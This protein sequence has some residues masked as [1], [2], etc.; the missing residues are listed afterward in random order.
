KIGV[1]GAHF[2]ETLGCRN[3]A[4][5][6]EPDSYGSTGDAAEKWQSAYTRTFSACMDR[7]EP[8]P[9]TAAGDLPQSSKVTLGSRQ[10]KAKSSNAPPKSK[11][12]RG[13]K[14]KKKGAAVQAPNSEPQEVQPPVIAPAA[15]ASLCR[16]VRAN[17]RGG[18]Q[19]E[20]CGHRRSSV[21][22][23]VSE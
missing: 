9:L 10:P 17:K 22:R 11:R 7:Y 8:Q 13:T 23:A 14:S 20:N 4:A 19:I 16:Q 15:D 12:L 3:Q 1:S 21:P 2:A 6:G 5:A 18:Y